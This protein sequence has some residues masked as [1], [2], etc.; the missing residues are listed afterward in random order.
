VRSVRESS[1]LE[2]RRFSQAD[3]GIRMYNGALVSVLLATCLRAN[4]ARQSASL[5]GCSGALYNGSACAKRGRRI[6]DC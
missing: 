1:S 2:E 5:L 6:E 3:G 4:I